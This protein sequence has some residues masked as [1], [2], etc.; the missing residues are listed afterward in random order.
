MY[1]RDLVHN[2]SLPRVTYIVFLSKQTLLKHRTNQ[3][4]I[5]LQL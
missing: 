1:K 5:F 3:L 2:H 4:M